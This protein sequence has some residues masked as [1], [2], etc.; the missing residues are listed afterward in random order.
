MNDAGNRLKVIAGS[1]FTER[2][3]AADHKLV[4]LRRLIYHPHPPPLP[5][6][7]IALLDE[8]S[9][10]AAQRGAGAAIL[11]RQFVLRGKH[12]FGGIDVF[13]Y[14]FFKSL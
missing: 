1:G 12:R 4:L 2:F 9:Q 13:L 3:N 7:D 6:L 10:S 5:G 11:L 14:F 8:T